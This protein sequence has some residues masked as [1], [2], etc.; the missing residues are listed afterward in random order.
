M[1]TTSSDPR[2]AAANDL[3]HALE[4]R[5]DA[6]RAAGLGFSERQHSLLREAHNAGGLIDRLNTAMERRAKATT[7]DPYYLRAMADAMKHGLPIWEE[8][9]IQPGQTWTP[10]VTPG[11]RRGAKR[12]IEDAKAYIAFL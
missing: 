8:I 9:L 5:R 1:S 12:A 7:A 3:W 11:A 6:I 4:A 10:Y 2:R